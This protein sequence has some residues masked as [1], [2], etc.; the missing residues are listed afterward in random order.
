M[1]TARSILLSLIFVLIV[2]SAGW[3]AQDSVRG[4]TATEVVIGQFV[5][6]TGQAATYGVYSK[7]LDTYIKVV[8]ESG[9]VNGRK[10][11]LIIEDD[12]FQPAQTLAKARKMVEQDQIFAMVGGLGTPSNLGAREYLVENKVP[13]CPIATGGSVF[14]EPFNKYYFGFI[15]N[16]NTEGKLLTRYAVQTL[17]K[18]KIAVAHQNDDA[19][20]DVASGVTFQLA[21]YNLKPVIDM[22]F[23]LG[24]VDFS[25]HALKLKQLGADVVI[26]HST[27]KLIASLV[28][29][30]AK[31]GYKP[32]L[33]TTQSAADFSMFDLAGSNFDGALSTQFLLSTHSD[34]PR[35][36]EFRK[37]FKRFYPNERITANALGG[38]TCGQIFVE[39]LRRAGKN[40]TVDSFI[41]A[42][43]TFKNWDKA[44][45]PPLTY[46]S[47]DHSGHKTSF[48]V[49]ADSKTKNF[50]KTTDWLYLD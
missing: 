26:L 19:G 16:F 37:N 32:Q 17:K 34:D 1:K 33:M 9:G 45:C 42:M 29:E 36:E 43:E 20:K 10:I 14:F 8:N 40:F 6:L 15:S 28:N 23:E 4:V 7:G 18:T 44:A 11:R 27:V 3:G 49:K 30:M 47:K 46:T 31:I 22:K 35:V 13:S 2:L 48:I 41:S 50:I 24:N 38:W 5:P 12:Q 25:G 39:G 21:K